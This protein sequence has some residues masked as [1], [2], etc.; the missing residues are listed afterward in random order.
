MIKNNIINPPWLNDLDLKELMEIIPDARIVGG[1]VRNALLNYPINDIDLATA[2]LPNDIMRI[3]K[4]NGFK[5]IPT[6]LQHGT[7]TCFK[8]KA[9]EITTLRI[10]KYTDGRHAIV[11]FCDSWEL[12]AQRRDF[13]MNALYSDFNGNVIDYVG[14][15]ED[16]FAKKLRFI[17]DPLIR[18]EEDHLRILRF[19]RFYSYYADI[20]D[21]S[22]LNACMTQAYK[23]K[24]ISRERCTDEFIKIMQSDSW[25]GINLMTD[26]IFAFAGLPLPN[27]YDIDTMQSRENEIKRKATLYG[28]IAC[29]SSKHELILSNKM[30]YI[31]NQ[32]HALRPMHTLSQYVHWINSA[33]SEN[34][35]DGILLKGEINAKVIDNLNQWIEYKFPLKGRDIINLGIQSGPDISKYL[36]L[37]FQYF[38]STATPLCKDDLL[39]WIKLKII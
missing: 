14:G 35:W 8:N 7:V 3:A 34:L 37:A 12:D 36:Q 15:I 22:S 5:V 26:E 10:D 6:G 38:I 32:L 28:K 2:C 20:Y 18:I 1:A 9:Y 25:K 23:L 19:F 24:N 13:T 11:E 16:L 39:R 4:N 17:G 30:K 31:L 27:K 21:I 33:Y 29:F